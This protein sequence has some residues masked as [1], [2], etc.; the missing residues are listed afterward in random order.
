MRSSLYVF[1]VSLVLTGCRSQERPPAEPALDHLL[2]KMNERLNLMEAVA[3]TKYRNG[4]PA[5]DAA[6]EETM[7]RALEVKAKEAS[8][9]PNTVR[10]FFAAQFEAAKLVQENLFHRWQ[11]DGAPTE[12]NDDDIFQLRQRIDQLN[13]ELIKALIDFRKLKMGRKQIEE[14]ARELIQGAGID[15][16]V[17]STAIRPLLERE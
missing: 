12:G 16:S 15:D 4:L 3:R 14:R 5:A 2:G 17:R 11:A 1:A 6:R 10:W 8:L 7:L 13:D 9:P